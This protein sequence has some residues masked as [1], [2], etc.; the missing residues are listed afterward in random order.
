MTRL[1]TLV[2]LLVFTGSLGLALGAST[3]WAVGS[4]GRRRSSGC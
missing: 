2:L 1:P 4:D 3:A